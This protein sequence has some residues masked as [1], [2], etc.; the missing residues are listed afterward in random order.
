ML[1][2]FICVV[3]DINRLRKSIQELRDSFTIVRNLS[4]PHTRIL[5]EIERLIRFTGKRGKIGMDMNTLDAPISYDPVFKMPFSYSF[6]RIDSVP[7]TSSPSS[8]AI[9]L[10]L[11]SSRITTLFLTKARNMT[12]DSPSPNLGSFFL[13]SSTCIFPLAMSLVSSRYTSSLLLSISSS[14]LH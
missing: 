1:I 9:F 14:T 5:T 7:M 10:A 4:I 12:E 6:L 3:N 11:L 13:I 2:K 8:L